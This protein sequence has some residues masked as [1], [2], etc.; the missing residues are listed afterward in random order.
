MAWV[1]LIIAG[2]LEVAWAVGMKLSEGFTR[3]LISAA[4]VAGMIASFVF[5]ALAL[6]RL[7]LGTAY[8]VWTGIGAIGTAVVGMVAFA[9]PRDLPRLLSIAAIVAGVIGLKATS[10]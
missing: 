1:Y 7:P 9:E 3:P 6:K 4:T 5:L 10:P 8:T 2:I